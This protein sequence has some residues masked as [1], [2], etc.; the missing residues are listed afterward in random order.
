M[1]CPHC[2]RIVTPSQHAIRLTRPDDAR[3][4][5][6]R[7]SRCPNCRG[8]TVEIACDG[9]VGA[10]V[11]YRRVHPTWVSP[12]RPV[13]APDHILRLFGDAAALAHVSP[14]WSGVAARRCLEAVLKEA[15]YGA[16]GKEGRDPPLA[17]RVRAFIADTTSPKAPPPDLAAHIDA[18]RLLGNAGAHPGSNAETDA[19][20]EAGAEDI[21]AALDLLEAVLMHFHG[22]ASERTARWSA[23]SERMR[24]YRDRA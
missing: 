16:P 10:R 21:A 9:D 13:G 2:R 14:T 11:A 1:D 15:G 20:F 22:P 24:R 6:L 23:F 12:G 5:F 3:N 8:D 4:W 17:N 7:V 19:P 18:V